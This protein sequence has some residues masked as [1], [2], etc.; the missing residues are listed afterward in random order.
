[1]VKYTQTI[2]RLMPM[3]CL[4][5]F[6]HFVG[7]VLRGLSL[8]RIPYQNIHIIV[9]LL[10]IANF[11]L[12]EIMCRWILVMV[13]Y[14]FCNHINEENSRIRF[15]FYP[16]GINHLLYFFSVLIIYFMNCFNYSIMNNPVIRVLLNVLFYV[17]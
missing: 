5:V 6:G 14:K 13:Q 17:P 8:N 7:L 10:R 11:M 1:M 4:S 3:N 16:I 9:D 15:D 12:I 2:R